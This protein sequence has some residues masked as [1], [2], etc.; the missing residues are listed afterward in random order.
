MKK[1]E[2]RTPEE[3]GQAVM[4]LEAARAAD[5]A[6]IQG[7]QATV[8]VLEATIKAHETAEAERR[9]AAIKARVD[10]LRID[11]AKAGA[12]IDEGT[13]A[14]VAS[15]YAAGQTG[16]AEAFEAALRK[17]SAAQGGSNAPVRGTQTVNL[18]TAYQEAAGQP[19]T[20]GMDDDARAGFYARNP[21]LRKPRSEA[22]K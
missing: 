21:Y 8:S 22:A 13:L 10:A 9:A 14:Q 2:E 4:A 3:W 15:L 1:P 19:A 17:L 12:P 6:T 16:A 7:L 5:Q 18:A 11:A 20:G